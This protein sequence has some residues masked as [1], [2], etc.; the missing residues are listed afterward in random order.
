M[1]KVF[2]MVVMLC[3]LAAGNVFATDSTANVTVSYVTPITVTEI[4]P[5]S[6]T[7]QRKAGIDQATGATISNISADS[8]KFQSKSMTPGCFKITGDPNRNVKVNV[9]LPST[10]TGSGGNITV[11]STTRAGKT[12]T[13]CDTGGN[14]GSGWYDSNA[15]GTGAISLGT[16]GE[17]YVSWKIGS[18]NPTLFYYVNMTFPDFVSRAYSGTATVTVNYQ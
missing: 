5:L 17:Q 12:G 9:A 13:S 6:F 7:L 8:T 16:G 11:N 1:L 2:L 3:L 18:S 10:L 14:W 15:D 4:Q